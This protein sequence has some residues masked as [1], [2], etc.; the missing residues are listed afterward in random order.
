MTQVSDIESAVPQ[1]NA[2]VLPVID[3]DV[4]EVLRTADQL[5]PYMDEAWRSYITDY[6]FKDGFIA[7]GDPY[8]F[9]GGHRMDYSQEY[10]V[11]AESVEAMRLHLLEQAR[12][13][14]VI[15]NG[16]FHVAAMRASYEFAAAAAS[17]YNNWQIAE[18]LDKEPRLRGTIHV[19]AED[20]DAAVREIERLADHPQMVQIFLPSVTDR[21]YG[22]PHFHPIYEAAQ[23]HNLPIVFHHGSE[24]QTALGYTRYYGEWHTLAPAHAAQGQ[25]ASLV[26]NGV[27]DRFD[28]LNFIFLECSI[29]WMPWFLHRLDANVKECSAEMPW[30]KRLPSE[31]IRANVRLSTQPM[32]DMKPS[33]YVRLIEDLGTNDMFMFS[34]DYPHYDADDALATFPDSIGAELQEAVLFRNALATYDRLNVSVS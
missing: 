22:H 23:R 15:I 18:W 16:F 31:S 17:A 3:T 29:G 34:S 20:A 30:I 28:G 9:R 26:C 7:G 2:R 32:G 12:E 21:Q 13:T 11:A 1:G 25:L 14:V 10:G 4:H 19:V 33:E 5:V 24:T 6:R 27:L 8:V